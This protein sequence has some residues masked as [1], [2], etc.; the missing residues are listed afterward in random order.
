MIQYS[1]IE[2][3]AK[4]SNESTYQEQRDEHFILDSS[5]CN[6]QFVETNSIETLVKFKNFQPLSKENIQIENIQKMVPF[7]YYE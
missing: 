4:W 6:N 7:D 5:L 2:R 3:S 1:Y